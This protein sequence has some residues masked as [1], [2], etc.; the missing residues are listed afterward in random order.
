[1]R[2]VNHGRN[3]KRDLRSIRRL[4]GRFRTVWPLEENDMGIRM[5]VIRVGMLETNCYLIY[6]EERK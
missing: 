6:D 4:A 1:M 3:G 5:D 2:T